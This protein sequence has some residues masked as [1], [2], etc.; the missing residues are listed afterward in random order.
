METNI[1]GLL[2]TSRLIHSELILP[3][4]LVIESHDS[5]LINGANVLERLGHY[6]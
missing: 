1:V 6:R 5:L 2:M 4:E 3:P